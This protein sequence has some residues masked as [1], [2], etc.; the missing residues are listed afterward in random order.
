MLAQL[1]HHSILGPLLAGM[2]GAILG[3]F[4]AALVSRWPQGRSILTGR[5]ACDG[6]GVALRPLQLVPIVSH[7]M[8]RGKCAACGSAIGRDSLIIELMATLIGALAM[9]THPGWTGVGIAAFGWLMLP[10]AW[11]DLRHYWLP[12]P[13]TAALAAGGLVTAWAGL[14]P[15]WGSR[16][17][18]AGAGFV[19]LWAIAF[20][21]RTLRRREGLGGGDPWLLGAIGLWLGWQLLPLVL[22]IAS[23]AG[24]AFALIL[25]RRGAVLTSATRFP[26]GTLMATAAWLTALFTL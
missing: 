3:S 23:G 21:Y 9:A 25:Q 26:L 4:I 22:M 17:I 10:L 11:L 24:L 2:L 8:L 7:L 19:S 14:P 5:S 1:L 20:A 12:H 18:G 6:C 13:L 16:A 15:D